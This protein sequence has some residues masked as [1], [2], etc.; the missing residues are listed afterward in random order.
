MALL[1]AG[2]MLYYP[3]IVSATREYNLALR[4][5]IFTEL[6]RTFLILMDGI[7]LLILPFNNKL[8]FYRSTRRLTI[9]PINFLE[10]ILS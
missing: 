1:N 6:Y 8:L 5:D 9:F 3:H 10:E 2:F 7:S 4:Q